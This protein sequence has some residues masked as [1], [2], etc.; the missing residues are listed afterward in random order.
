[1]V[2]GLFCDL[3]K[4]Q[5]KNKKNQF[6]MNQK[7]QEMYY[8]VVSFAFPLSREKEVQKGKKKSEQDLPQKERK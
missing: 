4:T 8:F 2:S 5:N 6:I 7:H 3:S 1:L